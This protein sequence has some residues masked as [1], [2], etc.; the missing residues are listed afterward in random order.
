[1]PEKIGTFLYL[2]RKDT[3]NITNPELFRQQ[4]AF[5]KLNAAPNSKNRGG[6]KV[7]REVHAGTSATIH[8]QA[9]TVEQIRKLKE[10]LDKSLKNQSAADN[11]KVKRRLQIDILIK[12]VNEM[13]L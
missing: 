13:T 1:M 3:V 5:D 10:N 11:Q 8:T 4:D 9:E 12:K 6:R 2:D 7:N